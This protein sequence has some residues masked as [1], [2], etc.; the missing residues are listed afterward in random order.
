[1]K[2]YKLS[3]RW[4]LTKKGNIQL[5]GKDGEKLPGKGSKW[6]GSFDCSNNPGLTSLAGAP[7]THI[8]RCATEANNKVFRSF[9]KHGYLFADGILSRIKSKKKS[10]KITIYRTTK[11]GSIN[12][13]IFVVQKGD[14]FSHGE[15]VKQASHDLRYKLSDRDTTKY[16]KWTLET[17][18]PIA[19]IIGAYRVITGACET[20]TK[21]WCEGKKLP[22][23]LSVKLAIRLTKGAYRSEQFEKF[24]KK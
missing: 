4:E 23:R 17:V 13:T 9:I 5:Y 21:Q 12:K 8:G 24:F 3:V 11:I 19:E 2:N 22:E 6:D 18:K 20:G 7:E 16:A 14:I 1:M 10:G 15:T